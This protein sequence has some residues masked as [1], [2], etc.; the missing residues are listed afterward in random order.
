MEERR[1]V[2]T[3]ILVVFLCNVFIPGMVGHG[4]GAELSGYRF[5]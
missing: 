1:S 2:L 4:D 5:L 3:I